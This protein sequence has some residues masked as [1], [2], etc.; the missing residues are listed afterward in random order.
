MY[1]R[2]GR[3]LILIK[4]EEGT[5]EFDR[6]YW[7]IFTGRAAMRRTSWNA[8]IDDYRESSRWTSLKQRSRED[9]ELV[10]TYIVDKMGK[11]DVKDLERTHVL[12][13]QRANEHRTRFA[14]YVVQVLKILCDH[15]ID[16]GWRKDNPAAGIKSLK[17][18][19]ERKREHLPWP[20]W[21]VERF[22][23]EANDLARLIFE[24]GVG[25]AQRPSD[26]VDF[27]WQDYNGDDLRLHQN[28][29]GKFLVLPCTDA[30]KMA[31]DQAKVRLGASPIGVRP[32]LAKMNG[33]KMTYRYMADIMLKERKRLGL[34]DFD[35]HALRYRGIQ[36]LAWNG[37][38]DDEIASYSGH[39]T[40][41]M[42][43]KYAG[44]ARQI[45]RARQAR[46][47]RR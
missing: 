38:T 20:D 29:T 28:K 40:K 4:A 11:Q 34:E 10:L 19:D 45:M 26:W 43:E 13:A 23:N 6:I 42:I 25:S 16:L 9:Y 21:A 14:N 3:I 5:A 15:A 7:E 39:A 27:L 41:A 18:P 32:I 2:K 47:K 17:T 31:L 8:L 12:K 33:Q 30:L 22:R 24:I 37:C 36:E 44:E 35:L 46:E 1:F